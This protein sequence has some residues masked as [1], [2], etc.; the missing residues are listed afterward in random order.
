MGLLILVVV[1]GILG[2]LASIV[3]RKEDRQ[4]ILLNLL[5]GGAGA[6]L[7]GAIANNG[8]ILLGISVTSLLAAFF[9]TVALLALLYFV[10][11]RLVS[12]D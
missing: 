7:A 6:V 8:S 5:F 9:G 2:W 12:E 3:T 4:G 1:G 10:R 11:L